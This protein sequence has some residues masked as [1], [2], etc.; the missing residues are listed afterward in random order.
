M[1]RRASSITASFPQVF[2]GYLD[3]HSVANFLSAY[4]RGQ[5]EPLCH[6][7]QDTRDNRCLTLDVLHWL[8]AKAVGLVS[9]SRFICHVGSFHLSAAE[10]PRHEKRAKREHKGGEKG[11]QI[12][13]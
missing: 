7:L 2:A 3:E 1:R 5:L 12:T 4:L 8:W 10:L 11:G 13:S 9:D 6:L